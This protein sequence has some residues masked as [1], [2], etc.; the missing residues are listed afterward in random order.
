MDARKI[1]GA[2]RPSL[3]RPAPA[4]KLVIQPDSESESEEVGL[5]SIIADYQ[6]GEPA[7]VKTVRAWIKENLD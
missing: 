1:F 2:D 7:D 6:R 4:P 5:E 3:A